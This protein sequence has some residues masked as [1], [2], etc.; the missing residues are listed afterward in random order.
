VRAGIQSSEL[1]YERSDKRKRDEKSM[2]TAATVVVVVFVVVVAGT[3]L[4]TCLS[5]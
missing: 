1:K 2:T 5:R 3:Y 4:T